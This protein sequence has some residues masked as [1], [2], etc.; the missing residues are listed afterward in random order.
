MPILFETV[1][2]YIPLYMLFRGFFLCFLFFKT[3]AQNSLIIFSSSGVPF[4]LEVK[5][6]YKQSNKIEHSINDIKSD[7][8]FIEISMRSHKLAKSIYLLEKGKKTKN[9]LF[10]YALE[11]D[12]VKNRLQLRFTGIKPVIKIPDPLVPPKPKNDTGFV[13]KNKPYGAVYEVKEGKVLFK[14][15][16]PSDKKCITPIKDSDLDYILKL[17]ENS[18]V[19][20]NKT[21]YAFDAAANN[22]LTCKQ[23]LSLLKTMEFELDRIKLVKENYKHLCDKENKMVLLES[24]TYQS[25]KQEMKEILNAKNS[26]R[27]VDCVEPISDSLASTV[28]QK[29]KNLPSDNEK[30]K[31]IEYSL[32]SKCLYTRHVRLFCMEFTHDREK[33]ELCKKNYY[34]VKDKEKM[35]KL[36][37]VF[38]F[39]EN[40]QALVDFLN[41]AE[42]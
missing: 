9:K 36:N 10:T 18:N 16:I 3:V 34:R 7:T 38:N 11:L 31:Y 25:S 17:I 32:S 5:S 22:C 24:V 41:Q 6:Y 14:N 13:L 40:Y 15:N 27:T 21:K 4:T 33:L 39:T 20:T 35:E 8:L 19:K 23:M 26:V 12:S 1:N 42:E 28:V 30:L 37:D 29:I 2:Y